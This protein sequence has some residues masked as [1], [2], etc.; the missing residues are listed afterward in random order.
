MTLPKETKMIPVENWVVTDG[1][2]IVVSSHRT[3]TAARKAARKIHGDATVQAVSSL[4][5]PG[6]HPELRVRLGDH[7]QIGGGAAYPA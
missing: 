5:D 4:D 2:G 7:V 3:G 6:E 1:E